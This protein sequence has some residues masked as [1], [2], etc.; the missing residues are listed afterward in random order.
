MLYGCLFVYY[1]NEIILVLFYLNI[2]KIK[3]ILFI[4]LMINIDD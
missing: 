1:I 4:L 2:Y 3:E